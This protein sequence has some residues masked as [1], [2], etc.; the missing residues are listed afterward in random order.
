MG[1][2]LCGRG[3]LSVPVLKSPGKIAQMTC[4]YRCLVDLLI[5][6]S[7]KDEG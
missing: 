3:Q 6:D 7:Y 5:T 2:V 4:M 1:Y